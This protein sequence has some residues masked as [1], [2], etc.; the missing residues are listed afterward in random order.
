M[1]TQ[2]K[3]LTWTGRVI[4][5]LVGLMLILSATMKFVNPPQVAEQFV[6]KLGY[7][8]DVTFILG[9]VEISCAILYLIP[10]TAVLGA[11]LLTGYLGGAIASHVRIHDNFA[12][13]L[14]GG[15]LVWLGLYLRCARVRALLP[16]RR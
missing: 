1:A 11:I 7:P 9:I 10:Q 12:G 16:I 2:N 14:I 13:A 5:A 6:D 15:V 8:E 4:T 3:A